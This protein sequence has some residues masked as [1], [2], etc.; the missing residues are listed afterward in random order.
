LK[1]MVAKKSSWMVA[2]EGHG[3]K[4]IV[5]DGTR[6]EFAQKPF[7]TI[8]F[9]PEKD[10]VGQYFAI[11]TGEGK[12]QLPIPLATGNKLKITTSDNKKILFR[13]VNGQIELVV[14]PEISGKKLRI[15]T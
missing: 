12:V 13:I 15:E 9:A 11:L 3:C 7:Q 14:T 8:S 10:Q 2:F 1:A 5:L 4:E 6:Y